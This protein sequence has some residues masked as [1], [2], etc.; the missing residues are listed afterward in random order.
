MDSGATIAMAPAA[1]STRTPACS[2]EYPRP[3]WRNWVITNSVPNRPNVTSPT[4][5]TA[6]ENLRCRKN[7]RFSIGC[8]L[9]RS[10]AAKT[11]RTTRPPAPAPITTGDDQ[12][13]TGASISDQSSRPRP[14]MDSTAP[15]RSGA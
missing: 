9:A 4:E 1:G 8:E 14:T 7:S 13:R 12:P 15:T 3:N 5:P 2:A 6:A 10:Q 11:A